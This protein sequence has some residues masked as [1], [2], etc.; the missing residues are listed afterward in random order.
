M[1]QIKSG[2][3]RNGYTVMMLLRVNGE[4]RWLRVCAHCRRAI[5]DDSTILETWDNL[6]EQLV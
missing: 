6:R 3:C 2:M 4:F 5:L 1:C